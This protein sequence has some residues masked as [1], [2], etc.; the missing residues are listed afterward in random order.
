MDFQTFQSIAEKINKRLRK[1]LKVWIKSASGNKYTYQ[2]IKTP[3]D[4][5]DKSVMK[6]LEDE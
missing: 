6:F 1:E 3:K 5:L 2:P 4:E